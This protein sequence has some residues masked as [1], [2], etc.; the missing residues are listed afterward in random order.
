MWKVKQEHS[1]VGKGVNTARV[2]NGA[3]EEPEVKFARKN[4]SADC[5]WLILRLRSARNIFIESRNTKNWEKKNYR[6]E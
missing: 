3:G 1:A 2:S 5:T 6:E 4:I